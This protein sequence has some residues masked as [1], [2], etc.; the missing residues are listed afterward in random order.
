MLK[1]QTPLPVRSYTSLT[2]QA[3]FRLQGPGLGGSSTRAE[4]RCGPRPRRR[5]AQEGRRPR[6]DGRRDGRPGGR[7]RLGAVPGDAG[8]GGGGSK[9]G[10]ALRGRLADGAAVL[11]VEV[12]PGGHGQHALEGT[13]EGLGVGYWGFLSEPLQRVVCGVP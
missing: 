8:S 12:A 6:R 11:Q 7:R 4:G 13:P 1:V 2:H 5:P 3:L 10:G 9:A